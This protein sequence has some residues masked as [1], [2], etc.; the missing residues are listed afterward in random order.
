MEVKGQWT[1]KGRKV[2]S[3]DKTFDII[4][5]THCQHA[6][7]GKNKTFDLVRQDYYLT[8]SDGISTS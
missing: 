3:E 7:P 4:T 2:V 5:R 8:K 6:Y 1:L